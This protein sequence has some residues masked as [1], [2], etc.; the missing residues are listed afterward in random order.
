MAQSLAQ[1]ARAPIQNHY[2]KP[3]EMAHSMNGALIGAIGA[4]LPQGGL[5]RHATLCPW[6]RHCSRWRY[7]N[8]HAQASAANWRI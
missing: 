6:L 1:M 4:E 3:N 7:R 8:A 2:S 5:P